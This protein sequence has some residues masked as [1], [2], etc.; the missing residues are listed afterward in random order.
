MGRRAGRLR[1]ATGATPH[2][3]VVRGTG[4]AAAD[5]YL[6]QI[7]RGFGQ[8]K[9]ECSVHEFAVATPESVLATRLRN[10]AADRAVHGIL[11]Q[12]PLPDPLTLNSAIPWLPPEKDVEAVHPINAGLLAQ[13]RPSVVPSTPLAGLEILR[14]EGVDLAGKRVVV[15]GRSPIVGR[16]L[17]LLLLGEHATVTICHTRTRDLSEVTRQADILLVAAGRPHLLDAS[18]IKA[19]AIVVDFGI[20]AVGG[21]LLGDVDTESA[22]A[23]AAAITPVPGGTGPVTTAL[24]ARNLV[25]LAER[26]QDC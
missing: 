3:A 12:L 17:A 2:L 15:V 26:R 5:S 21:R 14:A 23:V 7:S 10:L 11:V 13:G 24:L 18:A 8:A 4:D 22:Q 6:R 25:D 1:S 9:L 20:T 19:G 16:P